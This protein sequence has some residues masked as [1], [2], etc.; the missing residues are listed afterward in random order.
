[1][2]KTTIAVIYFEN[3]LVSAQDAQNVLKNLF[4]ETISDRRSLAKDALP[5]ND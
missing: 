2:D 3:N 5:G 4:A 1:M